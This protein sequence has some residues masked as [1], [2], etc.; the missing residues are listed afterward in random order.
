LTSPREINSP[1]DTSKKF[2]DIQKTD[3]VD[4]VNENLSS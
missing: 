2:I 1:K 4:T 3:R